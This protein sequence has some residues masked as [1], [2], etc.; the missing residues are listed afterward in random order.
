M[1]RLPLKCLEDRAPDRGL[2][3]KG[4][5]KWLLLGLVVARV[6]IAVVVIRQP[7][8]TSIRLDLCPHLTRG[9]Y[10][11]SNRPHLLS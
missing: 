10:L 4:V 5:G 3:G 11:N 7:H 6:V 2:E 9:K 8:L 1:S